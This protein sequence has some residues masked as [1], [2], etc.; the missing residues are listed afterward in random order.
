MGLS[1]IE[2]LEKLC[3]EVRDVDNEFPP[4]SIQ[5]LC[6]V[7]QNPGCAMVDICERVGLSFAATSRNIQ[8]LADKHNGKEGLGLLTVV[9]DPT[10]YAYKKVS[11][12]T[13]GQRFLDRLCE[14]F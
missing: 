14:I 5:V 2:K 11:L 9:P 3:K 12:T 13:K 4:Q 8:K 1:K 6:V 7:S 10:N